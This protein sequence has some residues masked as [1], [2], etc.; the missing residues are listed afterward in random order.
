M[1][2]SETSKAQDWKMNGL[3][4]IY[5]RKRTKT[6]ETSIQATYHHFKVLKD[7]GRMYC[8][9]IHPELLA[10]LFRKYSITL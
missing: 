2:R 10:E 4:L 7:S 5:A 6:V 9:I 3:V 8:A 1:I